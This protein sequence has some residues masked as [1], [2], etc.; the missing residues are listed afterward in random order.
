ML[1]CCSC[2]HLTSLDLSN[3]GPTSSRMFTVGSLP[4]GITALQRLEHLRLHD[5]TTESPKCG[6]S[7]LTQ[8]T[9]V[10]FWQWP[11]LLEWSSHAG[12]SCTCSLHIVFADC[13][14]VFVLTIACSGR[15]WMS[16]VRG[17]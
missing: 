10:E 14:H 16:H 6:I 11:S 13:L 15:G 4:E 12:A 2:T 1:G 7:Q 17:T 8:L 5:C 9:N 3:V